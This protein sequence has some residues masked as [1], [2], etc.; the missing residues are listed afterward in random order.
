VAC[1]SVAG[2]VV[3]KH[4]VSHAIHHNFTIKKPQLAPLF[5][6]KPLQKHPS[7]SPTKFTADTSPESVW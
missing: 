7:T 2:N 3:S 5:S 4:H 6:Q 1:F